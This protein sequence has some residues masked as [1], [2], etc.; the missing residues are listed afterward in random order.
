MRGII[1]EFHC[2][3]PPQPARR[4]NIAE[5]VSAD[6]EPGESDVMT[7]V[8]LWTSEGRDEIPGGVLVRPFRQ[9]PGTPEPC[10]A[11]KPG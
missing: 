11:R 7:P 9:G 5:R 1:A 10:Y 6:H 8:Q 3:L 4:P 2:L